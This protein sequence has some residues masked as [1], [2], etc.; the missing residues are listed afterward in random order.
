MAF[1]VLLDKACAESGL[2]MVQIAEKAD[3]TTRTLRKYRSGGT[4]PGR[5]VWP[6]LR[7]VLQPSDD[8]WLALDAAFSCADVHEV[9]RRAHAVAA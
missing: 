1:H 2:T 4:Y 6:R 8:L 5:E 9:I 7:S 3:I